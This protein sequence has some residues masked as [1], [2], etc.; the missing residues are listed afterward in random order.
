MDSLL[1]HRKVLNELLSGFDLKMITYGSSKSAYCYGEFI[2]SNPFL[3]LIWGLKDKPDNTRN[4]K[5]NSKLVGNYNFENVLAAICIGAYFCVSPEK[6][7]IAME[8]YKPKNNRS[9]L[10]KT[11]ANTLVLD[12]YNANPTNMVTVIENFS[13]QSWVDCTNGESE[14]FEYII[15]AV[16]VKS[17]FKYQLSWRHDEAGREMVVNL[18]GV[19]Y[20]T[21]RIV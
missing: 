11:L 19:R 2:A 15:N 12:A 8:Q 21:K 16:D 18:M 7:K 1:L 13:A 3:E 14:K 10:V 6:I 9:Q 17:N 5:I 20:F 4:N